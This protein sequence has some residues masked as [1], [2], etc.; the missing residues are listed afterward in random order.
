MII[1]AKEAQRLTRTR[2][3]AELSK[4]EKLIKKSIYANNYKVEYVG[5][6]CTATIDYLKEIGYKITVKENKVII[7]WSE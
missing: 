6:L 1:G 5:N 4:I 2:W 7:D 3:Q